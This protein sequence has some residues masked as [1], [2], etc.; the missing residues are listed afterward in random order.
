MD[1]GALAPVQRQR[2]AR[3]ELLLP[4]ANAQ[5]VKEE[6]TKRCTKCHEVKPIALFSVRSAVPSGL[7]PKCR[8]CHAAYYQA[9]KKRHA[10]SV[11]RWHADHPGKQKEFAERW[12]NNNP[13]RAK[14]AQ[15][16]FAKRYPEK[17]AQ[18]AAKRRA[19]NKLA[20]PSWANQFFISE[21]YDLAKR[22]TKALGARYSVDH[23]VPLQNA[24]VCGLHVEHNL[25]VISEQENSSK[26][27]YWWPDMP[28]SQEEL[29][30]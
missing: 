2:A 3:Q 4:M 17:F 10:E 15:A 22:R 16:A 18:K 12:R 30:I 5:D 14:L 23:I 21:I 6:L 24:I 19:V 11:K 8:Q 25:R 29:W 7:Q 27:N 28:T 1:R 20:T 9:N 13:E 26:C